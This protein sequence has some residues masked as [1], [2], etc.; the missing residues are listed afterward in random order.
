MARHSSDDK[1]KIFESESSVRVKSESRRGHPDEVDYE[2]T[3]P[4][5]MAADLW[6]FTTDIAVDGVG[7]GVR[8]ETME[9]DIEVHNSRGEISIRSVEGD[10]V[11]LKSK[12]RFEAN[13]VDSDISMTEVEGEIFAESIDGD[14]RL[15][16]IESTEVEAKTVDG[17]VSYEGQI[18]DGGRYRLSTHDGD[19]FLALP[20][21]VD[22]D[23]S[24]ATFD[25]EFQAEFPVK[26]D[27]AEAS[28]RFSFVL[29]RGGARIELNSFDGDIW[30]VRK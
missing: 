18:S 9:G 6:G 22:A 1:I 17:D 15:Q 13:G 14:I 20:D 10:I 16:A 26:L 7:N 2:L 4:N 25:G 19:V 21:G 30:L 29:G 8:V 27:R 3:I 28:G 24:V 23:V 11:V 12:G 5:T